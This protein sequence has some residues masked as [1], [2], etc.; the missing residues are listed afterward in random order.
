MSGSENEWTHTAKGALKRALDVAIHM[1]IIFP[2][3]MLMIWIFDSASRW[4]WCIGGP[5]G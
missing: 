3:A 1:A 4:L 2:T 5:C